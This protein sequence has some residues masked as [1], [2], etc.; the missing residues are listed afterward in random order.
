[1]AFRK[2]LCYNRRSWDIQAVG[3]PSLERPSSLPACLSVCQTGGGRRWN[4]QIETLGCK[5]LTVPL[6][7]PPPSPHAKTQKW[8]LQYEVMECILYWLVALNHEWVSFSLP[9]SASPAE[10]LWS[11]IKG[12]SLEIWKPGSGERTHPSTLPSVLLIP[13]YFYAC[14]NLINT[15]FSAL[16]LPQTS[17]W[18]NIR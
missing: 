11:L 3:R 1:M 8:K 7:P 17:H 2:V 6:L 15:D 4:G 5:T 14:F 16:S 18:I 10:G 12:L 13:R 9:P